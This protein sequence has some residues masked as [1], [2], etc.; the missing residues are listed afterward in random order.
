MNRHRTM[1]STTWKK[2]LILGAGIVAVTLFFSLDLNGYL[3]LASIK[4]SRQFFQELLMAHPFL[5]SGGY[6]FIYIT[7]VALNLPGAAVMTLAG[8]ALFGFWM[9][10][11]LVSFAST[12][13]ATIACSVARYLFRGP[14]KT[15]FSKTFA[16]ID[17]GIAREGAFYLFTL[18]LIPVFPFFAINLLMG[19]TRLP[20]LRFYWVSQVGMLPGT[21]VY[22]NAGKELGKL[23]SLQGI[24][25]PSLIGAF[26]I[27]G[28]FPLATK[29][30]IAVVRKKSIEKLE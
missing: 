21:L 15:R 10:T 16:K 3:T 20:L 13:G 11:I 6:F 8:G 30:T 5:V 26:V 18:R 17:Q 1:D 12:M 4:H 9:G 7:V 22:I 14:I 25:S 27:L 2:I 29:K 23:E 28:L 24:L 19:L